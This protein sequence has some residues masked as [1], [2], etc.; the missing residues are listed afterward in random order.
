MKRKIEEGTFE[1]LKQEKIWHFDKNQV[2]PEFKV[3]GRF[4]GNWQEALAEVNFSLPKTVETSMPHTKEGTYFERIKEGNQQDLLKYYS[5]GNK[6]YGVSYDE[7]K[8]PDVLLPEIFTKMKNQ[9]P[10]ENGYTKITRQYPG[11]TWP[12]HFD[13]YHALRNNNI[14]GQEWADPQIR[15][16]W[17]ALEDWD[18]G[19]FISFGNKNWEGWKAGDIL[20]FDWL[21]PHATANSGTTPRHSMFVT[22][23]MT[24]ALTDWVNSGEYK[25]I[26]I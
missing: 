18:W 8:Q 5:H 4:I 20:Y 19:H 12:F 10:I 9:L 22:G 13:N 21:V 17:I 24:Q 15:R 1:Y 14:K 2:E 25:E 3:I 16:I 11:Q 26:H 7:L 6:T 23:Y